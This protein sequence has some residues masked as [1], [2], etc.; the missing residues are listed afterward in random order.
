MNK[1]VI[2]AEKGERQRALS[3]ATC[4]AAFGDEYPIIADLGGSWLLVAHQNG[5]AIANKGY[6]Y[7]GSLAQPNDE[8][9]PESIRNNAVWNLM[10]WA[11]KQPTWPKRHN[12]KL[13]HGG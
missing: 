6:D 10:Q 13:S 4:Y 11:K 12:D 9:V 7:L 2:E 5:P 8:E 3:P 1:P